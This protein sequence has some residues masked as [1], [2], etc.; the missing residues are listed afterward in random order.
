M[1][2]NNPPFNRAEIIRCSTTEYMKRLK[3]EDPTLQGR[4]DDFEYQ[5]QEWIKTNNDRD[6]VCFGQN[7]GA[8]INYPY[9]GTERRFRLSSDVNNVFCYKLITA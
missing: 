9:N 2:E 4:L 6:T 1:A 8:E 5:C 7:R 3:E